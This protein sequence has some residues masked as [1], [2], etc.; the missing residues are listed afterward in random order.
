[1]LWLFCG[2]VVCFSRWI[3]WCGILMALVFCSGAM[4]DV[5]LDIRVVVSR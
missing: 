3:R 2:G 4:C 1:M 5:G